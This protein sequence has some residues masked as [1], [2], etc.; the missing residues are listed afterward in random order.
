MPADG[1]SRV[2]ITAE[3]TAEAERTRRRV[4]FKTTEGQFVDPDAEADPKRKTADVNTQG[5][6]SVELRSGT[7]PKIATIT[8][9]VL[10]TSDQANPVPIQGLVVTINVEFTP[11]DPSAVIRIST[12][13]S[14]GEAD[15]FTRIF[16]H[17]DIAPGLPE[18][19]RTVTFTT[20]LGKFA[21]GTTSNEM[22]TTTETADRSHRAT[23][24]LESPR[25]VGDARITANVSETTVATFVRFDP[26]PPDTILVTL[27]ADKLERADGKD[28]TTVTAE[29]RR[30]PG[31]GRVTEN[32]D[33]RF[34]AFE[35]AYG[36]SLPLL[37]RNQMPS[38]ANQEATATVLLG[39]V[40]FVGTA[41]IRAE[42]G[43]VRGEEDIEIDAPPTSVPDIDVDETSLAF[44][45]VAVGMS[46]DQTVTVS[47]V[48][49]VPLT[50]SALPI[51]PAEFSLENAPALPA[52]IAP[53]GMLAL[54][55]RFSPTTAGAI[56]GT[57][58]INSNDP[59]E[60]SVTI[61]LMG[62]GT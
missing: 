4:E 44:G 56:S 29:L 30:D 61:E 27:G 18:G 47:N 35:K 36:K 46:S 37:F 58:V 50:L 2:V 45:Q 10:D 1:F 54:T 23:V 32:T 5:F 51:M 52:T 24:A 3:I 17:A 39:S 28:R 33:V 22:K 6:A 59:D 41:T 16:V 9:R 14:V 40:E 38:N 42:V 26:A 13:A 15:G 21:S 48:G 53:G 55:V 8:V 60:G 25:E 57:L 43:S 19:S 31:R 62:E 20:D 34:S 7:E 11:P 12:S 49:S